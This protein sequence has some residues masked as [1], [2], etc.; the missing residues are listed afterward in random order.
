[1]KLPKTVPLPL[2]TLQP[3]LITLLLREKFVGGILTALM[4]SPAFPTTI[5]LLIKSFSQASWGKIIAL[6]RDEC[7][8][9]ATEPGLIREPQGSG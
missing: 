6:G 5:L 4:R 9:K 8:G 2:A 3:T 7:R 1:L